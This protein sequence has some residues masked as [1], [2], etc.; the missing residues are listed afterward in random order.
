MDQ[1]VQWDVAECE[2]EHAVDELE[3]AVAEPVRQPLGVVSLVVGA[4]GLE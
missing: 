1:I 3:E 2:A 4:E